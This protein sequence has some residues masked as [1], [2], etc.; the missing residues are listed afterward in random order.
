MKSRGETDGEVLGDRRSRVHR[1]EHLQ[2]LVAEGCFVRVVDN[3]LTGKRSNL[4]PIL[5]KIEF[6]EADMGDPRW[7][8]PS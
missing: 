4:D 1:L 2:R 7:P 5:D 8:G 3:L 6:V